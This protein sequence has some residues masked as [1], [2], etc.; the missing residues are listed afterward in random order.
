MEKIYTMKKKEQGENLVGI[1]IWRN[2][3]ME[4]WRHEKTH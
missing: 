4:E 1:C 2:T 3:Y